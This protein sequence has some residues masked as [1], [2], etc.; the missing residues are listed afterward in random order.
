MKIQ[1]REWLRGFAAMLVLS[2]TAQAA[3]LPGAREV[4]R[5]EEYPTLQAAVDALPTSGGT[6]LLPPGEF[7]ITKP[8][9]ITAK[10]DVQIKGAGTATHIHNA[11]TAGEPAIVVRPA[12]PEPATNRDGQWRVQLSDFRVTG[13]KASGHGILARLVNEVYIEGVTSSYNG[14][15]GIVLDECYEDPRVANCLISYNTGTGLNLK[16]CHDIVV[17]GNHF[18]E[19]QDALRCTDGFNL[20]MT[21]NNIDD[22]LGRG[23]V[24]ES[25]YG[26]VISGNMIEECNAPAVVLDRDCYGIAISANVIA[27]NVGG[28]DLRDAHGISISANAFPLSRDSAIWVRK[29]SGRIAI[30]GNNFA[31]SYVGGEKKFREEDPT[32]GSIVIEGAKQVNLSG[33][34]FASLKPAALIVD[35]AASEILFTGNMVIDTPFDAAS[36]GDR[37][38]AENNHIS[39]GGGR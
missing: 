3:T 33:N 38:T 36:F 34:T 22:H 10:Q 2:G 23:V 5:A 35:E 18:E 26:S 20:C 17:D 8:L 19:N 39:G 30:T 29:D 28:V 16:G 15:D 9:M 1:M 14:G 37:V 4:I 32:V 25:T 21:G 7:E 27:H 12:K 6:V 11:N 24:I 13:N 31:N